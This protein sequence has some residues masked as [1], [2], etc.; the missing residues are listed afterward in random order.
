MLYADDLRDLPSYVNYTLGTNC[1][2]RYI[3]PNTIYIDFKCSDYTLSGDDPQGKHRFC[4]KIIFFNVQVDP[5]VR[6]INHLIHT[7][8]LYSY[9]LN[10]DFYS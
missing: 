8:Y 4:N 2:H 6:K 7:E 9:F 3:I 5:K 10:D 1:V